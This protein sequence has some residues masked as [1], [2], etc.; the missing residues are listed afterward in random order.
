MK[1]T[2]KVTCENNTN[3]SNDITENAINLCR[4][5]K[6][7]SCAMGGNNVVGD[8][9]CFNRC[10]VGRYSG[11][12]CFSYVADSSIGRYCTIASRVSIGAFDH[13]LDWLSVH[14]FQY[15]DVSEIYG[16]T[17]LDGG[18]NLL[19]R[20]ELETAL[21]NDVWIGD[22]VAIR[23][24]IKV[25]HG[26][27]VGLGAVVTKDVEPYSIVVGNPARP[28]KSRFTDEQ[29]SDLLELEWWTLDLDDLKG[30]NFISIADAI[31]SLKRRKTKTGF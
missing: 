1:A 8:Y 25:G 16:A 12:G 3:A 22:N 10:E 15:R 17:L 30:I 13:P 2:Q 28:V 18:E 31:S 5:A 4:G 20:D 14:E 21:G 6:V 9:S 29:I 11:M 24:G 7:I 19:R 27:V 23:R 26:A